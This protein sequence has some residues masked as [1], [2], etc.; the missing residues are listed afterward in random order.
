MITVIPCTN[1]ETRIEKPTCSTYILPLCSRYMITVHS[2]RKSIRFTGNHIPHLA[3][4]LQRT[5][6]PFAQVEDSTSYSSR[7]MYTSYEDAISNS[8]SSTDLSQVSS[9]NNTMFKQTSAPPFLEVPEIRFHPSESDSEDTNKQLQKEEPLDVQNSDMCKQADTK[10]PTK[11]SV[12]VPTKDRLLPEACHIESKDSVD[13]SREETI[14]ERS[15]SV[16][17]LTHAQ[18]EPQPKDK[19]SLSCHHH[20]GRSATLANIHTRHDVELKPQEAEQ[21]QTKLF[22]LINKVN[23]SIADLEGKVSKLQVADDWSVISV[24][25]GT[26]VD[27]TEEVKDPDSEY[28]NI[29]MNDV[30]ASG[31]DVTPAE[32]ECT[33]RNVP[34]SVVLDH[35]PGQSNSCPEKSNSMCMKEKPKERVFKRKSLPIKGSQTKSTP[36]YVRVKRN[37]ECELGDDGFDTTSLGSSLSLKSDIQDV[38]DRLSGLKHTFQTESEQIAKLLVG[39]VEDST[40]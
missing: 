21:L 3:I 37:T 18:I 29:E 16:P 31:S 26:S 6:S 5:S 11:T 36:V 7:K 23:K 19:S 20:H 4:P 1:T 30:T 10:E 28:E 32:S 25:S 34:P 14:R 24:S 2:N 12:V 8:G 40:C 15:K 27:E 9:N 35:Q 13:L 22:Q 38:Q 39:I 33:R 17:F